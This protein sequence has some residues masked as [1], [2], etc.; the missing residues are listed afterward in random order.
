MLWGIY[1]PKGVT[2]GWRNVHNERDEVK[3]AARIGVTWYPWGR[4]EVCL[5]FSQELAD[6]EYKAYMEE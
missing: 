5:K 4:R 3:G 1:G 6:L 2:G